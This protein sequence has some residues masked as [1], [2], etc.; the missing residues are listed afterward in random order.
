MAVSPC[1]VARLG[2]PDLVCPYVKISMKYQVVA[3][4]ANLKTVLGRHSYYR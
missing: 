4:E 3:V 1:Y 2:E